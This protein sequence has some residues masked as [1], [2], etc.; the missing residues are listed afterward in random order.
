MLT[1]SVAS[2][3]WGGQHPR[4]EWTT[5]N[6]IAGQH[7]RNTQGD[8]LKLLSNVEGGGRS[9]EF[10]DDNLLRLRVGEPKSELLRG[11]DVLLP[12][13]LGLAINPPTLAEVVVG[14]SFNKFLCEA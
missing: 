14:P 2:L 11:A 7:H 12:D 1:T 3:R 9:A 6:G 13:D 8:N 10:A 4:N 5:S